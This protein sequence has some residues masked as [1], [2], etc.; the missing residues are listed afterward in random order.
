MFLKTKKNLLSR[1]PGLKKWASERYRYRTDSWHIYYFSSCLIRPENWNFDVRL[2][3]LSF[4]H[5]SLFL[6][7]G[8]VSNF[9]VSTLRNTPI[10]RTHFWVQTFLILGLVSNFQ[11]STLR[12][13]P[14]P[15]YSFLDT[16]RSFPFLVVFGCF[17]YFWCRF[18]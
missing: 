15:T 11:V 2:L 16:V 17:F 9:Q 7:L 8:L 12:N 13:T 5:F 18:I 3:S 14:I 1:K 4:I 10:P 6:I